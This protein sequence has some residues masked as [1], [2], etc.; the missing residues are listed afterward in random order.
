MKAWYRL[1]AVQACGRCG[2]SMKVGDVAFELRGAA[3]WKVRRCHRCASQQGESLPAH[4]AEQ[5]TAAHEMRTNFADR[6]ASIRGLA[7]DFKHAQGNDR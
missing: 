4:I 1:R 7:R 6:I 3:G 2:E 5:P